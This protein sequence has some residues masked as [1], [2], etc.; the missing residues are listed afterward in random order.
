MRDDVFGRGDYASDVLLGQRVLLFLEPRQLFNIIRPAVTLH[1]A[2]EES[3]SA[4]SLNAEAY[5]AHPS[6]ARASHF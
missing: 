2:R 6:P 1:R 3:M 5:A 4:A